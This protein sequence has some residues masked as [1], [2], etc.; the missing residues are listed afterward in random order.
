MK[1]NI[2]KMVVAV[3]ALVALAMLVGDMPGAG[4]AR[5]VIVKGSALALFWGAS[6]VYDKFITEG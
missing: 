6:K 3:M 2:I 4:L 5:F 1:E